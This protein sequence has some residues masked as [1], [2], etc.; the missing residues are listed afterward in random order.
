MRRLPGKLL[1]PAR[2]VSK[3]VSKKITIQNSFLTQLWGQIGK[4]TR[5]Y[6]NDGWSKTAANIT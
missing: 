5:K 6:F 1:K 3:F 4:C 2:N